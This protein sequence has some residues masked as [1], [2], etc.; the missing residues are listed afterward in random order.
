MKNDL[1]LLKKNIR[2]NL[3]LELNKNLNDDYLILEKKQLLYIQ[4]LIYF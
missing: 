1:K 3:E 4:Q 2:Q